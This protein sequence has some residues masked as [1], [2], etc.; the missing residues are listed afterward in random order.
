MGQWERFISLDE[1]KPSLANVVCTELA[2]KCQ[3]KQGGEL[4]LNGGF[5]PCKSVDFVRKRCLKTVVPSA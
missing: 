1:N 4:V 3:N 5:R 2:Y